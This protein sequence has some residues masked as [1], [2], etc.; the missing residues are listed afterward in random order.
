MTED[1]ALEEFD[2][3]TNRRVLITAADEEAGTSRTFDLGLRSREIDHVTKT[4]SLSL[5]SDEAMAQDYATLVVDAGARASE[6]S[7]RAVCDYV[8]S[9]IPG[10]ANLQPNPNLVTDISG[11]TISSA[12][13]GYIAWSGTGGVDSKGGL[14]ASITT[15][16]T[17][18]I[19]GTP[20]PVTAGQV[21]SG[22]AYVRGSGAGT[23]IAGRGVR[24]RLSWMDGPGGSN[25]GVYVPLTGSFQRM[26]LN[27]I[28]VPAGVTSVRLDLTIAAATPVGTLVMDQAQ[29]E[30]A[31]SVGPYR[32]VVLAPPGP[33]MPDKS[34]PAY[35]SVTNMFTNPSS[36]ASSAIEWSPDVNAPTVV[37]D[38]T[39]Y[40]P[41]YEGSYQIRVSA[42]ATG[43]LS[44][45]Q[46]TP[47]GVSPGV[48]YVSS[49]YL[50]SAATT[51][52]DPTPQPQTPKRCRVVM[53][54]TGPSG[55]FI[56]DFYSP[57]VLT[58]TDWT[59]YVLVSVAPTGAAGLRVFLDWEGPHA[60]GNLHFIDAVMVHEG[61]E[62]IPFFHGSFGADSAYTY[63]WA[64]VTN[65]SSSSRTALLERPPDLYVWKPGTTAWDFLEPLTSSVGLRLFCDE[66]R[67][68]RLIDPSVYGVKGFVS[69]APTNA[70]TGVDVISRDDAE[71]YA[72]GVVVRYGWEDAN[73]IPQIRY[74]V[75]GT[76]EKVVVVDYARPYPGPGAAAQI[77]KRR[78]GTGRLQAVT[79]VVQWPATPGQEASITLPEAPQQKGKI[80]VVSFDLGDDATMDVTT[81]GLIDIPDGSWAAATAKW[82]TVTG[83]WDT[84]TG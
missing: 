68:W 43:G 8:L 3:R 74:D 21:L 53:R 2:P 15:T 14:S 64:G 79:A 4:V 24:M 72:S 38:G 50:R 41:T 63:A 55:N 67:V 82:N 51:G 33:G 47:M 73:G 9:K 84:Y 60:V 32:D 25:S 18:A 37:R 52:D 34:V 58:T 23:P 5:A 6:G 77:L 12:G 44:I 17:A 19:Y 83:T 69:I 81:R 16:S 26:V 46:I 29:L 48:S 31:D 80:T 28:T 11:W 78:N 54:Y 66:Q 70:V 13:A 1:L 39:T 57:Y 10:V 35:W 45:G 20:V 61:T 71:V 30:V 56:Q 76:P 42:T 40:G 59:R 36:S 27:G 65:G 62:A 49:Q 7:I 75:A 22:S